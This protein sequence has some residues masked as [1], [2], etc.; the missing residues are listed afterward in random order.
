MELDK[1]D[2][3]V[4][5]A[6]QAA[7]GNGQE[8]P[9][10]PDQQA[11]A[12]AENQAKEWGMVAFVVGNAL[13]MIA[14]SLK[15]VYTEQACQAWGHAMVPV[16]DKYGWNG[17]GNVPEIGLAIATIGLALPSYLAVKA[18]LKKVAPVPEKQPAKAEPPAQPKLE[19][20]PQPIA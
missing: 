3:V 10:T 12:L 17:P 4:Q 11:E 18:E 5:V 1:L 2:N 14:P 19:P 13:A 15:S 6:D 16:A 9:Q 7:M 8:V 20:M